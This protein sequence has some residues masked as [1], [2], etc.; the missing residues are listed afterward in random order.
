MTIEKLNLH[1]FT[2][3]RYFCWDSTRPGS[4][5]DGAREQAAWARDGERHTSANKRAPP[6]VI[7]SNYTI[8]IFT[9][10]ILLRSFVC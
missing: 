1:T 3:L 4:E 5:R 10:L 9:S 6:L 8:T 7:L 2:R